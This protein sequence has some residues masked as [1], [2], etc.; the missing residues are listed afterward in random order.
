MRNFMLCLKSKKK[1]NFE[2]CLYL[3]LKNKTK[4][5][6]LKYIAMM[7]KEKE[8]CSICLANVLFWNVDTTK[9]VIALGLSKLELMLNYV[10]LKKNENFFFFFSPIADQFKVG[11]LTP[12]LMKKNAWGGRDSWDFT[13]DFFFLINQT[14]W[15]FGVLSA[16]FWKQSQMRPV[17]R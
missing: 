17:T 3:F 1:V 2:D 13:R 7:E 8:W 12:C 14:F 16:R 4:Q 15:W 11:F 9:A 5:N 10:R 6:S